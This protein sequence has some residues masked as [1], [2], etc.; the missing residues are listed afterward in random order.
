M[1]DGA[2]A[3]LT[4]AIRGK[5]DEEISSFAESLGVES[6]LD[7]T[8]EGMQQALNPDRA[9]DCTIAYLLSHRG[10]AHS[11]GVVIKDR[12]A[13]V[14]KPAPANPR[15]TLRLS[16]PNYLRLITDQLP[17]MR[18]V[19]FRRLRISGDRK[20]ARRMQGMFQS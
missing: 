20:F 13:T 14:A 8:F 1:A 15:V 4:E 5:S 9:E 12:A 19:L 11:Y 7:Q 16:V 10:T 3:M 17:V 18:A 6:L 2:R